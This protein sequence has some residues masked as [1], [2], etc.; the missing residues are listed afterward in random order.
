MNVVRMPGTPPLLE[1]IRVSRQY[2]GV[3]ALDD[4]SFT[5][6]RGEVHVLFGENGAGKSTLISII[7]G[8]NQPTSGSVLM[9]GE[10]VH[11][12]SVH[13]A[14]CRGITTVF[15]ELSLVP[16]MT[17][18]E[19]M[20]LGNEATHLGILD[21]K[22]IRRQVSDVLDQLDFA[23]APTALVSHL[24]RAEQQMV[25]IARAFMGQLSVLILDEP[26]ASLTDR[27]AERVFELAEAAKARGVGIIY[28][29]HRLREIERLADRITVL[30]DGRHIETIFADGL[31]ED[32]LIER[33]TGRQMG[34][35]Y[36]TVKENQAARFW[37]SAPL[38]QHPGA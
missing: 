37:P 38:R 23:L 14:R 22:A 32:A 4:V 25:E 3:L 21:K 29:T 34:A 35:I 12:A 2:P 20:C 28:I 36:P 10:P 5:L 24:S 15:Q 26:T 11:F 19:N 1:L 9:D 7:S 6:E 27:E 17:V 13:D 8:A 16:S 31:D 30:R 18:E 33:M